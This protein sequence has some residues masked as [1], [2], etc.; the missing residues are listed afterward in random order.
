VIDE[1]RDDDRQ[2][3][4]VNRGFHEGFLTGERLRLPTKWGHRTN[5]HKS[6][7]KAS[8]EAFAVDFAEA[9]GEGIGRGGYRG[10]CLYE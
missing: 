1:I 2:W 7:A 3:L 10:A 9:A 4:W 8:G 6:Y 5:G